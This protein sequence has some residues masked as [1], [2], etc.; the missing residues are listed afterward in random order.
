MLLEGTKNGDEMV[1]Y[2]M[3]KGQDM[4]SVAYPW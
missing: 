2:F 4:L 3:V 1:A